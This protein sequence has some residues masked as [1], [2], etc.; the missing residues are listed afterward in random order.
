MAKLVWDE[1]GKKT[2]ETGLDHGVVFPTEAGKYQTGYAWNGLTS[3]AESPSGAEPTNLYA[4]NIKY[5]TLLSA[6]DF[7]GTINAYSYPP[8]FELCDGTAEIGDGVT[9]AQ[10]PRKV[11]GLVYRTK[12]GNDMEGQDAGYKLHVVYGALA[13]PSEKTRDTINESPSAVEFSW[14]FTTTPVNVPGK[15]PT[16]HLTIDSTRAKPEALKKIEDALF[17]TEEEDSK[18][19][20]PE[21]ILEILNANTMSLSY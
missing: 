10:Q 17:G 5:L 19:L 8:E 2:F 15:A 21:E 11:F 4:D 14:S 9:I 13:S 18:L 16:A 6:E 7:G 1:T 12:M 20:M 3:I